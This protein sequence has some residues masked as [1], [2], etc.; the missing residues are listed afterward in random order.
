MTWN[1]NEHYLESIIN[2]VLKNTD[3]TSREDKCSRHDLR[4]TTLP[5]VS[6]PSNL[7]LS[8]R[9]QTSDNVGQM[10]VLSLRF[11]T[12]PLVQSE[13]RVG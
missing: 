8:L 6:L 9:R 13:I 11:G 4:V 10:E 1:V 12:F 7:Q 5:S 2:T 3:M